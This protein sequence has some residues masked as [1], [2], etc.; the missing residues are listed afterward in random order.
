MGAGATAMVSVPPSAM[1]SRALVTRLRRICC[2]APP[3]ART[4]HG[5]GGVT[6]LS[7]MLSARM[8]STIWARVATT[9]RMSSVAKVSSALRLKPSRPRTIV[10]PPRAAVCTFSN[11][12]RRSSRSGGRADSS[13]SELA[14]MTARMLLKSWA[15]PPAS[16]PIVSSFC[17]CRSCA[18]SQRRSA[19]SA[20]ER[21]PS[22]RCSTPMSCSDVLSGEK[23][24]RTA[25]FSV[26]NHRPI[27]VGPRP[28]RPD[29]GTGP[30]RRTARPAARPAAG[31]P[32]WARGP[33]GI[34]C[35]LKA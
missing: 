21:M 12:A 11:P 31:E 32:G 27:A 4:G 13:S 7:S 28:G 16:C 3:S 22:I 18:S 6:T 23:R 8:G 17:A 25:S 35:T 24:R 2:T 26:V 34:A 5:S 1:A 14:K 33:V 29:G 15:I 9:S 19:S 20:A 30:S 10:A